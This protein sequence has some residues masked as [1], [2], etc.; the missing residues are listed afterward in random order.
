MAKEG[1]EKSGPEGKKETRTERLSRFFRN[2]N[3][4]GALALGGAALLAPPLAAGALGVLAG[5]DA[6]QA[7]GFEVARQVAKKRRLKKESK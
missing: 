7:G 4:L 3:A 2:I 5:I 6:V 1:A